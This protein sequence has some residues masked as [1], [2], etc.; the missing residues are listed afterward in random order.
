MCVCVRVQSES[1]VVDFTVIQKL[2]WRHALQLAEM[3][4]ILCFWVQSQITEC[5]MLLNE[6]LNIH[7]EIFFVSLIDVL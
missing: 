5:C 1:A 4:F 2:N 6:W 3:T 7:F